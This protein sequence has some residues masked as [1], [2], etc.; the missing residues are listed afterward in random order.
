MRARPAATA[1]LRAPPALALPPSICFRVTRL[2]NAR[3]G[4][5]LAPPDGSGLAG[6]PVLLERVD[7]LLAR[8]VRTVHFCGGEPTLHPALPDLLA[9]VR[10]QGRTS[11][12]TTNAIRL[13]A[14]LISTLRAL[15]TEVKVSLHGDRAH[16]DR[17]VGRAAF[18]AT[19]AN[20]R[21]LL[22]A[23]VRTSLQTTLVA[24][25]AE[26]VEWAAAFSLALGV[27]RLSFL[28][29]LPRGEGRERRGEYELRAGE[30]QALRQRVRRARRAHGGRLDVRW[31]DF[32]A[33]PIHVVEADGRLILEG[34]T[35][36]QD[37]VLARIPE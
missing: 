36:D 12:L 14:E 18:D 22:A 3:C 31:L 9:R 23:G 24:G 21:R 6:A 16:H 17:I 33:R 29:F 8:G 5:C 35:E 26:V 4:F 28:P 19:T 34:A 13:S 15:R 32:T 37:R 7:W 10:A 25:H 27:R 2:C 20:L 11:K 30:R 1:S